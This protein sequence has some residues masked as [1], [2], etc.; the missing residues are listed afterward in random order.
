[1]QLYLPRDESHPNIG[2]IFHEVQPD[3]SGSNAVFVPLEIDGLRFLSTR[4]TFSESTDV[5]VSELA[6][7]SF[8]P[9]DEATRQAIARARP[10]D[11]PSTGGTGRARRRPRPAA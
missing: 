4:T 8:F 7:E 9:A 3:G 11:P 10:A 6:I 5:T 1:M 2:T